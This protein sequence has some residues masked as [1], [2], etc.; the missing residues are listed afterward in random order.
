MHRCALCGMDVEPVPRRARVGT[1][2]SYR[3]RLG[4][5]IWIALLAAT[6]T[7]LEAQQLALS[8]TPYAL[9]QKQR[10]KKF[11]VQRG[12]G[13]ARD[14]RH[15]YQ[16]SPAEMLAEARS[17]HHV[18][19]LRAHAAAGSAQSAST[20]SLTAAW[21]PV[22]PAQVTT[23]AYGAVT[24][25]VSSIA[26]DPSDPNG[27]TVYIGTTGGGVWKSTNA[28][29]DPA[30]VAF[31]PLTDTLSAYA[32]AGI[33]SLS[34]GAVSVQPGGTGVVLAGTG[35]PNDATDSYY[36]AGILRSADGGVTWN[37]ISQTADTVNGRALNFTFTGNSFAGFAWSTANTNLVV[38]AVSQAAQGVDVNAVNTATSIMGIYYS[39]DAGQTWSMASI[40]DSANNLVQS[41]QTNFTTTGNAV[42]SIVWNPI[43]QMFYAAVRFHGYYQSADGINWMRLQN[44]PGANLTTAYCPA[45]PGSTGSPACPIF[46][47]ALAVQPVTGDMFAL[48]VDE[49]NL[50]QGLWQDVCALNSGA[51]SSPTVTFANQISDAALEDGNGDMTIPQADYDLYLAAVPS[52]QDTLLFAGTED[53]YRC[54]LANSCAWRNTTHATGC[55]SAEVAWS[56]HAIDTTLGSLGLLYFSND[57]GLWRPTDAVNQQSAE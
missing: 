46:R 10:T 41:D 8:P 1:L 18:L 24:G 50:D 17:Q 5:C 45:N 52:Q 40:S 32:N 57:G 49:N 27:N 19:A 23:S 14:G 30:S 42:T 53:V 35:D 29:G 7:G 2:S 38:A 6:N 48:T 54:S 13:P 21:Q 51:C 25:R 44:Q 4:L 31:T 37:L 39:Q 33:A 36:G 11:L 3:L 20:T 16:R 34:I 9:K 28:A 47:G 55:A 43:R 12:I 26:V 22:G 56:Q 15:I